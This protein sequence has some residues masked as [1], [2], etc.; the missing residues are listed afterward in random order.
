MLQ[1]KLPAVSARLERASKGSGNRIDTLYA[2]HFTYYD[3][4]DGYLCPTPRTGPIGIETPSPPVCK[5][6]IHNVWL[7]NHRLKAVGL[8][9][10]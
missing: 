4:Q 3:V 8:T 1:R 10:D 5:P 9:D 2:L 6:L 7:N